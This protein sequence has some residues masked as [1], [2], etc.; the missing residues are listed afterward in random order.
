M[1]RA[2]ESLNVPDNELTTDIPD[3]DGQ[4]LEL[5][6]LDVEPDRRD[7]RHVLT[8]LQLV[9]NGCLAGSV[10]SEEAETGFLYVKSY[11]LYIATH[12]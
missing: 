2:H 9:Q 6:G 5:D 4:V 12:L 7:G 11:M 1:P 8:Q 3:G 10:K